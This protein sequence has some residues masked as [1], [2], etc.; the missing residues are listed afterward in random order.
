M[1]NSKG[2]LMIG[3]SL[4]RLFIS[5]LMVF[6]V[7]SVAGDYDDSYKL[8]SSIL[9]LGAITY[10]GCQKRDLE[11]V[12]IDIDLVGKRNPKQTIKRMSSNFRYVLVCVGEP[13][14]IKDIDIKV[15]YVASDGS[16]I[17][18]VKDDKVDPVAEVTVEN[19]T[20]GSYVIQIEAYEMQPGY[21]GS[22]GYYYLTVAHD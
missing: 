12:K 18:I 14:R 16:Y 4:M 15:Y 3:G 9:E 1:Y 20:N 17:L 6:V 10:K 2:A 22:M 8:L 7:S 5:L 11:I 19:P 21:E 13:T